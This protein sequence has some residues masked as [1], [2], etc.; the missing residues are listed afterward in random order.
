MALAGGW[1]SFDPE[2][3]EDLSARRTGGALRP[4]KC[5]A[6]PL[7]KR[8]T[9]RD[10]IIPGPFL[11]GSAGLRLFAVDADL[12][13]CGLHIFGGFGLLRHRLRNR[14]GRLVHRIH[15]SF[16]PGSAEEDLIFSLVQDAGKERLLESQQRKHAVLDG[17]L[18]DKV[19]D[20]HRPML[21]ETV[22]P[23]DALLQRRGVPGQIHIDHGRS[24]LKIQPD[25]AGIRRQEQ[26]LSGQ[27]G[28]F[29]I[30]GGSS[31]AMIVYPPLPESNRWSE[32]EKLQHEKNVLG[33]YVS[34]HPLLKYE[35]EV[36]ELSTVPLGDPSALK[37][38]SIV[39]ACGIVTAVKRKIDKR[40][41]T[42]AFVSIEDFT[43]TAECI[44]FSDAFQK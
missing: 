19:D 9:R 30:Q 1:V 17:A 42:M 39:K 24:V 3:T 22:N 6:E 12:I 31:E 36:K 5:F 26:E 44:V 43:G 34:G 7:N 29:D 32:F 20:P 27:G 15:E 37:P 33:F 8:D 21:A 11:F 38:G 28:L 23:A 35:R 41:N 2:P 40:N 16:E 4:K 18:R 10:Q 13:S 25:P 14:S